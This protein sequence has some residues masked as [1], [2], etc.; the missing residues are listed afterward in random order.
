[1]RKDL[2]FYLRLS[3]PSGIGEILMTFP[4]LVRKHPKLRLIIVG[5]GIYREHIELMIRSMVT[6]DKEL[7]KAAGHCVDELG[8]TFLESTINVDE[9][10]QQIKQEEADRILIT[11]CLNHNELGLLLPMAAISLVT[12]KATE[13]FG[14]V[15]VE[16]MAAGW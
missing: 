3:I 13:A 6:G 12:S 2:Y 10:F 9:N 16:A 5:F 15:S 1:M 7:F 8:C 11:G 14:M 4:T